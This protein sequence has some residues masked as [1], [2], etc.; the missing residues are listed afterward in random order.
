[1]PTDWTARDS[2]LLSAFNF[3]CRKEF[4]EDRIV[5]AAE[6]RKKG[7]AKARVRIAEDGDTTA[8]LS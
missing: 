4:C 3:S 7:I 5:E 1:M 2:N 6:E 8:F